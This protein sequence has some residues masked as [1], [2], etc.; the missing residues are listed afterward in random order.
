M[1]SMQS[2]KRARTDDLSQNHHPNKKRKSRA[3]SRAERRGPSNFPPEFWDSL[4]RC[5]SRVARYEN[6]IVGTVLG[7]RQC[8]R[9]LQSTSQIAPV[10]QDTAAQIFAIFEGYVRENKASNRR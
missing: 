7:L 5:R 2:R 1:A 10:S 6:S 8:P 4:P 9:P 3:E